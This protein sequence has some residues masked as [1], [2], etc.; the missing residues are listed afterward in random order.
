[1][2]LFDDEEDAK[3]KLIK[4]LE[5]EFS[6]KL[7]ADTVINEGKEEHIRL[8]QVYGPKKTNP[9]GAGRKRTGRTEIIKE[10]ANNNPTFSASQIAAHFDC[11]RQY[12]SRVLK[13]L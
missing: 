11:S 13:R 1:M 7:I 2:N 4:L 10:Y 3:E 6:Y 12:I 9:R 8:Y 5:T